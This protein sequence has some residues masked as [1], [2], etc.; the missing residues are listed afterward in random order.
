MY[1]AIILFH[2]LNFILTFCFNSISQSLSQ[3]KQ[4]GAD[5][6]RIKLHDKDVLYYVVPSHG[7]QWHGMLVCNGSMSS[8][9]V[10]LFSGGRSGLW[11][12]RWQQRHQYSL[13]FVWL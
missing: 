12:L 5:A 7:M 11:H 8:L 6:N 13:L 9:V 1:Y 4:M 2:S 3:K 10:S